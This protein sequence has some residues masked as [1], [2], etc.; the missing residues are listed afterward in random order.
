MG[1]SKRDRFRAKCQCRNQ[2]EWERCLSYHGFPVS[3][4]TRSAECTCMWT[5]SRQKLV[6]QDRDRMHS[7]ST[8]SP[9]SRHE[10]QRAQTLRLLNATK[11]LHL[12]TSTASPSQPSPVLRAVRLLQ[13]A[14]CSPI[15]QPTTGYPFG[16]DRAGKTHLGRENPHRRWKRRRR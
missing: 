3:S 14:P 13:P 12:I 4:G 2:N 9:P 10:D 16:S 11:H 8:C 5:D 15:D 1:W 7:L 6:S